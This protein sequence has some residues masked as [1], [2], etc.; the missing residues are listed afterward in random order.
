MTPRKLIAVTLTVGTLAATSACGGS[1][2]QA[3]A[4][5]GFTPVK[6]DTLTVAAYVPFPGY[7]E[8]TTSHLTGGLEFEIAKAMEKAF[9]LHKLS[10]RSV[11]FAALTAGDVSN[12]DIAMADIYPT[13]QRK[14]VNEYSV[15]YDASSIVAMVRKGTPLS[16]VADAKKLHWGVAVGSTPSYVITNGVKPDTQPRFYQNTA[17]MMP[18]LASGKVNAVANSI[19]D[20]AKYV[21]TSDF[22]DF[23]I[24]AQF[25]YKSAQ[26]SSQCG[27]IQLPKGSKNL[28][29]VNREL[30]KLLANGS[31][32]K[33][34]KRWVVPT[35]NGVDITSIPTINLQP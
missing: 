31:I 30:K 9:G 21:G 15:C 12:Y 18:A 22:K 8:G 10:V 24:P 29:A 20:L 32:K 35:L 5:K 14:A 16:T 1:G 11:N 2:A 13:T 7:W 23:T 19:Q 27:A 33:W 34:R 26:T 6:A 28:A 4:D 3:K 25:E 17:Q